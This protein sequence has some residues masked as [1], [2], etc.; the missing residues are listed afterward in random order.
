MP[1]L[2]AEFL[3]SK[4]SRERWLR[5]RRDLEDAESADND[6]EQ[7]LDSECQDSL[8]ASTTYETSSVSG[9]TDLNLPGPRSSARS[10]SPFV[11]SRRRAESSPG[12]QCRYSQSLKS[13]GLHEEPSSSAGCFPSISN[14]APCGH[15]M[16]PGRTASCATPMSRDALSEGRAPAEV[17]TATTSQM[18]DNDSASD[19]CNRG[20]KDTIIDTVGAIAVDSYGNIA[21]GSSSGGIGM[22]HSGRTGP[23]ALVGIGTAIIPVDPADKDGTCVAAVTSGTGEHMA[24]TMASSVCAER[25][26]ASNRK[27][28]GKPGVFEEV[29]EDEA[30][31]ATIESEFMGMLFIPILTYV[32]LFESDFL[33]AN[34]CFSHC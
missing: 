22:K 5:W 21:A 15:S 24:T 18:N 23:A 19:T 34:P 32:F 11:H 2:H 1:I 28:A 4:G 27:V 6:A 9:S 26:Y 13:D 10:L 30:L 8:R 14:N 29:T 7:P 33:C 25:I 3:I 12:S 20:R 31:K 17:T 16:N